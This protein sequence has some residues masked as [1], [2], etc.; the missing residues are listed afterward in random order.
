[1]VEEI[2]GA[3]ERIFVETF[4]WQADGWGRRFVGALAKK[5]REGGRGLRRLRRTREPRT[6]GRVQQGGLNVPGFNVDPQQIL[7]TLRTTALAAF[8]SLLLSAIAASIGGWLGGRTNEPVGHVADI[9][10]T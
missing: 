1:M 4:I 8:F 2:E 10:R 6:A 9:D 7:G 5:A 3:R